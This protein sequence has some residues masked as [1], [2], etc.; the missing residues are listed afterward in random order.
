MVSRGSPR[1]KI[2]TSE[3][4]MRCTE[5]YNISKV[6]FGII[7]KRALPFSTRRRIHSQWFY[8]GIKWSTTSTLLTNAC[9][10]AS[11]DDDRPVVPPVLHNQLGTAHERGLLD[12]LDHH[13][14]TNGELDKLQ[15]HGVVGPQ[16][17]EKNQDSITHKQNHQNEQQIQSHPTHPTN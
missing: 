5:H 9:L 16:H 12:E 3:L 6:E 7:I 2:A 13:V 10:P 1:D 15:P 8:T 14:G 17:K 11:S 4:R